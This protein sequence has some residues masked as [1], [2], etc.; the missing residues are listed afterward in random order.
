M[1]VKDDGHDG[2]DDDDDGDDDDDDWQNIHER[3]HFHCFKERRRSFTASPSPIYTSLKVITIR[4]IL[5]SIIILNVINCSVLV[6]V[7][8]AHLK[9]EGALANEDV[10]LYVVHI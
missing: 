8:F 10:N 4:I 1:L 7:K 5:S 6:S 3:S 2:H 9:R